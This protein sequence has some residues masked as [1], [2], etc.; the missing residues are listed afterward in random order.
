MTTFAAPHEIERRIAELEAGTAAAWTS[1]R[2]ELHGL[3]GQEYAD[4]EALAWDRL[5]STLREPWDRL[6]STL[7]ELQVPAPQQP[8]TG[9]GA[10]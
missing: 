3:A 1:Y 9:A 5:Q 4:A 6:Q 10:G 7:R 8:Q 2:D